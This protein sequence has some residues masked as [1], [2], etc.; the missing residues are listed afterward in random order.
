MCGKDAVDV[1][2]VACGGDGQ[3]SLEV[4]VD[5]A[6]KAKKVGKGEHEVSSS[7][8]L[9]PGVLQCLRNKVRPH[10]C[11]SEHQLLDQTLANP[12]TSLRSTIAGT[13]WNTHAIGAARS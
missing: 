5:A 4:L 3:Q 1:A 12:I 13:T 2:L 6:K 11:S 9:A 10:R 7:L 8:T